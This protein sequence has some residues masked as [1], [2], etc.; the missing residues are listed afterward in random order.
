MTLLEKVDAKK[1]RQ[2][3]SSAVES[4]AAN[5][6]YLQR[7][8]AGDAISGERAVIYSTPELDCKTEY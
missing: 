1:L 5:E 7:Y 2:Y 6:S 8:V 4:S 3:M